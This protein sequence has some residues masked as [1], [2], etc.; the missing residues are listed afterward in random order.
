MSFFINIEPNS[1][2]LTLNDEVFFNSVMVLWFSCL[3]EPVLSALRS[4][5]ISKLYNR[6]PLKLINGLLEWIIDYNLIAYD[7]WY[8]FRIYMI[9]KLTDSLKKYL[10][11]MQQNELSNH[12]THQKQPKKSLTSCLFLSKCQTWQ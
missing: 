10:V 8:R 4:N 3:L 1:I 6:T 2:L 12:S 7:I 11:K 5:I 9:S